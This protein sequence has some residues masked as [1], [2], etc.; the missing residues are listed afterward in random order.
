MIKALED[1]AKG[2]LPPVKKMLRSSFRI[3]SSER[4]LRTESSPVGQTRPVTQE[5]RQ[6]T[7]T[8]NPKKSSS[9]VRL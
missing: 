1:K 5:T 3:D 2:I 6:I 8:P 9:F 4:T 7:Q